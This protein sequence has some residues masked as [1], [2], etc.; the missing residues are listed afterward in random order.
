MK[1]IDKFSLDNL[2]LNHGNDFELLIALMVDAGCAT[3]EDGVLQFLN[4]PDENL[5]ETT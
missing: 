2:T 4:L 1:N 3:Y 5:N